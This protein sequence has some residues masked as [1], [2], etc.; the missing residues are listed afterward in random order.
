[1]VY[2]D[3]LE[4][5]KERLDAGGHSPCHFS[6]VWILSTVGGMFQEIFRKNG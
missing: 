1:M 2:K 4:V 3:S 5:I 6:I